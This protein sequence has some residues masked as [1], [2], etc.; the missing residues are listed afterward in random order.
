V[1]SLTA[2]CTMNVLCFDCVV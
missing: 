1:L 2:V